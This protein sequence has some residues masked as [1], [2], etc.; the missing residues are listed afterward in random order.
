MIFRRHR[1][2]G[3]PTDSR[4]L[5]KIDSRDAPAFGNL[6]QQK[7]PAFQPLMSERHDNAAFFSSRGP[8]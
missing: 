4:A 1:W 5:R 2:H 8:S 7:P 6:P 3:R